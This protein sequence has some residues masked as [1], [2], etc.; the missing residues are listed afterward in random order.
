MLRLPPL[1]VLWVV[2]RGSSFHAT[3][4]GGAGE[5]GVRGERAVLGGNVMSLM[6]RRMLP[7][8]LID[9]ICNLSSFGC[10]LVFR[11]PSDWKKPTV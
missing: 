1:T 3:G 11:S 5:G 6:R 10:R 2:G 4:I 9:A 8:R 7:C